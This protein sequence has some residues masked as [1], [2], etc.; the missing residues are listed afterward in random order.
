LVQDLGVN[1]IH[2]FVNR[3]HMNAQIPKDMSLSLG[4]FGISL[5]ELTKGYAV[6][7]NGGRA[8]RLRHITSITDRNGKSYPIPSADPDWAPEKEKPEIVT[9][10]IDGEIPS[11]NPFKEILSNSQVYDPRLAHLMTNILNGVTLYGT[12]GAAGRLSRNL[13]GKTGTTNNYIDALFVGFSSNLVVGAWAGF[14]DNRTLGY[15]ETGGKTAL[16][17]WVDYMEAA[18]AKYGAPD[19]EV[20]DG[21]TN[22]LINKNTGKPLPP[23]SGEGFLESYVAGFDPNS[24]EKFSDKNNQDLEAKPTSLDDGSYWENQ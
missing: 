13:G 17:M 9:E 10:T 5:S 14:D 16:P 12:G 11:G 7:P 20:P 24:E 1:R 2:G 21:I 18:I 22:L 8:V 3:W 6:F 19:F 15:G 4:S 23:G